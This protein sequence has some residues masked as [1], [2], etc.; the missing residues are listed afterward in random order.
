M[1]AKKLLILGG[2]GE[3]AKLAKL[4][5]DCFQDRLDVTV[6]YSGITGHQPDLPC[7]VHVGGFGGA[8]GLMTYMRDQKIDFLVDATHPFAE[9]ISQHAYVASNGL[10]IPVIVLKRPKWVPEPKDKW[11]EVNDMTGAVEVLRQ[12]NAKAFLTIGIKELQQFEGLEDIPLVVRLVNEPKEDLPLANYETVIGRP[13][14]SVEDERQLIRDHKIRVLVTKNSGGDQTMA[15]LEAAREEKISVIMINRPP[16]EPLEETSQF[17][18]I[19]KWLNN[20]G[21]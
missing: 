5:V 6:S 9:K 7:H 21:A 17:D 20:H 3:A 15:K 10:K 13:P 8:Q 2:T 4:V 18:E 11:L 19:L 16:A 12:L 1:P 14:F